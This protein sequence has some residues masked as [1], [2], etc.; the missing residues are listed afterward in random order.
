M[1]KSST[2]D[3][4]AFREFERSGWNG[5]AGEY[6]DLFG[7][8]TAQAVPSLLD[9]VDARFGTR[10]LDLACGT[11]VVSAG[12][13]M[14]GCTVVGADFAPDMVADAA[15]RWPGA[16]FR[17][18]D[19][20]EMPFEDERFDAVASNFG[21]LHFPHPEIVLAHTARVLKSGGKL[22]FTVWTHD[23]GHRALMA[24]AIQEHGDTSV[25]L[26]S[27]PPDPFPDDAKKCAR[28]LK[29]AGFTAPEISRPDPL[30]AGGRTRPDHRGVREIH[31]AHRLAL[32]L[33]DA[34]GEREDTGSAHR[35]A[36]RIRARGNHPGAHAGE[37]HLRAKEIERARPATDPR[38]RAASS[39]SSTR[40]P[41]PPSR[42]LLPGTRAR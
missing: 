10:L 13:L 7:V 25:P 33:P 12:A 32:E 1:N 4:E 6:N 8:I 27:G 30:H 29:E 22:A 15:R 3:P 20:E 9:A 23:A 11:G 34:R 14:R 26:V 24:R 35:D 36:A 38:V 19:A 42:A 2:Y 18:C 21:F 40:R 17:H 41:P 39:R 5:A 16:E 31:R 37:A 28:A